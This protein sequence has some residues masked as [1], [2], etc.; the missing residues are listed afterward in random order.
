MVAI[1]RTNE[2]C[3]T[4]PSPLQSLCE[5]A[6]SCHP[7]ASCYDHGRSSRRRHCEAVSE[8]S[9]DRDSRPDVESRK[10]ARSFSDEFDEE[11]KEPGHRNSGNRE[12]A[13][14]SETG[15]SIQ[16]D[17]LSRFR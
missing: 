15:Q 9:Q 5:E 14:E 16:M 4:F 17:E 7:H 10:G 11:F 13:S 8:W 6:H 2:H 12:R 1:S 3:E